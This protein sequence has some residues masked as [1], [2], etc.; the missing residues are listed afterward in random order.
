MT[1]ENFRDLKEKGITGPHRATCFVGAL[2]SVSNFQSASEKTY[3]E[4]ENAFWK[5]ELNGLNTR[6][7]RETIRKVLADFGGSSLKGTSAKRARTPEET[8]KILD[9]A[10]QGGRRI[11][12]YTEEHHVVGLRPVSHGWR[13]VGTRLPEGISSDQ[14]LTSEEIFDHLDQ[15]SRL[16]QRQKPTPN[17]I[18][19]SSESKNFR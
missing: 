4:Y 18:T 6:H 1:I 13:M 8:K 17:I 11:L 16:L 10:R 12:V 15:P 14:V 2:D 19:F 7:T 3:L 5:Q 9:S